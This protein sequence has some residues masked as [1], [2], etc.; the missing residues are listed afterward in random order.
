[1]PVVLFAAISLQLWLPKGAIVAGGDFYQLNNYANNLDRYAYAWFQQVGQGVSNSLI[2]TYPYYL[3][4]SWIER[5]FGTNLIA[6]AQLFLFLSFSY[7]S[8]LLS[9]K[10]LIKKKSIEFYIFPSLL[11]ALNN[12]VITIFSYPWGLTH[13]FIIYLYIPLILVLF[14]RLLTQITERTRTVAL[15]MIVVIASIPALNNSAFIALIYLLQLVVFLVYL[16]SIPKKQWVSSL[17]LF[18]GIVASQFIV[19]VWILLPSILTVVEKPMNSFTTSQALGGENYV[20]NWVE[21]TSSNFFNVLTLTLDE[22]RHPFLTNPISIVQLLSATC[23]FVLLVILVTLNYRIKRSKR[24]KHCYLNLVSWTFVIFCILAVRL[25]P[26]FDIILKYIYLSPFFVFFRSPDKICIVLA[27]LYSLVIALL[28]VNLKTIPRYLWIIIVI[29]LIPWLTQV[30]QKMLAADF[31]GYKS[32]D[33]KPVYSYFI[34]IPSEYELLASRLNALPQRGAILSMP[35]SIVNSINWSNYPK[36]KFVGHDVLH[37]LFKRRYISANVFDHP[38]FENVSSFKG[39][40][41]NDVVS[42]DILNLFHLF[43]GEYI[44]WHK[45]IDPLWSARSASFAGVLN[46][47]AD[48]KI[49]IREKDTEYFSLYRLP[50]ES[51]RPLISVTDNSSTF[52]KISPVMYEVTVVATGSASII[53][54]LQTYTNSW[55]LYSAPEYSQEEC[56]LSLTYPT[57]NTVECLNQRDKSN[58][59][60]ILSFIFNPLEAD[61]HLCEGYANCWTINNDSGDDHRFVIFN[62]DQLF[63]AGL[64]SVSLI[65]LLTSVLTIIFVSRNHSK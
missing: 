26:P 49:L 54:F 15:F 5:L 8:F 43:G 50:E 64:F 48:Q 53:S 3:L 17:L 44:L 13:H 52:T 37:T 55:K 30:P 4:L 33:K 34:S 62:T 19:Y 24:E 29:I 39:L 63:I 59:V 35:Y 20:E 41:R 46:Q 22:N 2:V 21:G 10:I 31:S 12:F 56:A 9:L 18:T 65:F 58:V 25:S 1:M 27:L 45:D 23:L 47:M 28:L 60:Q 40:L 32:D 36:W 51:V 38:T 42:Q 14:I 6:F 11:Y 16:F 57:Y 61:H 7:F